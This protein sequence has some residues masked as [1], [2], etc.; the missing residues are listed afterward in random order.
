MRERVDD[1]RHQPDK[2]TAIENQRSGVVSEN[3]RKHEAILN[4]NSTLDRNLN[5]EI[6]RTL[7]PRKKSSPYS[8][9]NRTEN[10]LNIC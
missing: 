3:K 6:K 1:L 5:M 8:L 10:I 9:L 4:Q 7:Q 2:V